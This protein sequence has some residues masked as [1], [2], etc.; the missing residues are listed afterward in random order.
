MALEVLKC[1]LNYA[2]YEAECES[3]SVFGQAVA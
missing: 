1:L 3:E 2:V